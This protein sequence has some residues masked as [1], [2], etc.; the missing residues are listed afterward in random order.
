MD[1][2]ATPASITAS[3][4]VGISLL[5]GLFGV[6]VALRS[7]NG[8]PVNRDKT[9]SILFGIALSLIVLNVIASALIAA[10]GIAYIGLVEAALLLTAAFAGV[11][12]VVGLMRGLRSGRAIKTQSA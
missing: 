3:I 2:A 1:G 4:S 12:M 6:W 10:W 8:A 5:A 7:R 9:V 11:G